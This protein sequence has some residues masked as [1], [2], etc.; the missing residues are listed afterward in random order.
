MI[1]FDTVILGI[2]KPHSICLAVTD[3]IMQQGIPFIRT[4]IAIEPYAI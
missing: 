3:R 2:I 4:T 1:L